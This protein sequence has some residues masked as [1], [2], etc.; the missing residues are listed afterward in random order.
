MQVLIH[1]RDSIFSLSLD[2]ELEG[3]RLR[4]LRTPVRAPQANAYC[5]RLVGT[6]RRECLDFLIPLSESHL[7]V[8]LKEWVRHYNEGRPH[9]SLG[10]GL[11]ADHPNNNKDRG[12]PRWGTMNRHRL[13]E[14]CEIREKPVLG[15][16]HH[17]Y[18][19]EKK[20]A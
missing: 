2:R 12:V 3:F 15:G 18:S 4:V 6:I 17:E 1:D 11:P 5:E 10:P 13:P 20:A 7:R 19:L 9:M 14:R 16:L 8:M